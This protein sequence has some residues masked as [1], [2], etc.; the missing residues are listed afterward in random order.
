MRVLIVEDHL[1][2]RDVIRKVL[3]DSFRF[4]IVG[5]AADGMQAVALA[6]QTRPELILLDLHLPGQDG[7]AAIESIRNIVPHVKVLILSS[8]CDDFTVF[9]A[10]KA[11]VQGFVDKNTNSVDTLQAAINAIV[12][13][14]VWFSPEFLRIK[15]AR[16]RDTNSFDKL[17]TDRERDVLSLLGTPFTDREVALRLDIS[18]ATVAKHRFNILKKLDLKTTAELLR[19]AVEHGFSRTSP[20]AGPGVMLP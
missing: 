14:G 10:E 20:P 11:R 12:A 9:R 6:D 4:Q 7:F 13:G 18:E 2:F 16:H 8:H 1:M 19:F 3:T 15:T 5:E 17:L